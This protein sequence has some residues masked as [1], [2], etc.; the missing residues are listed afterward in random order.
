MK[1]QIKLSSRYGEKNYLNRVGDETSKRYSLQSEFCYRVGIIEKDPDNYSFVD[2]SG[3]PFIQKGTII[4]GNTVKSI[5]N[6]ENNVVIEF[7]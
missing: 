3:G 4:D 7:E 5:S 2:P 6:S 1:E